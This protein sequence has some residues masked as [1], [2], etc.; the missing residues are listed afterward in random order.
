MN[1]NTLHKPKMKEEEFE[2]YNPRAV[3]QNINK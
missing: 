3:E 2:T 1:A